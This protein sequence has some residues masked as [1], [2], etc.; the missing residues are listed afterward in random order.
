MGN[1][2]VREFGLSP[3]RRVERNDYG[4]LWTIYEDHDGLVS[5]E[6]IRLL[7]RDFA[8]IAGCM[9][10]EGT[11]EK[12]LQKIPNYRAGRPMHYFEV[13]AVLFNGAPDVEVP[14][15]MVSKARKGTHEC[16]QSN[17]ETAPMTLDIIWDFLT[18]CCCLVLMDP[19]VNYDFLLYYSLL[20]RYTA[21]PKADIV[22]LAKRLA[23][24][25]RVDCSRRAQLMEN[26]S[27]TG[28]IVE[29]I[30]Q[31]GIFYSA[32]VRLQKL[33]APFDEAREMKIANCTS[34]K[35]LCWMQ[36][37][38]HII[39]R[40][41]HILAEAF[42][43]RFVEEYGRRSSESEGEVA[44]PVRRKPSIPNPPR[45]NLCRAVLQTIVLLEGENFFLRSLASE[46][47]R[48]R[49]GLLIKEIKE[50]VIQDQ[51]LSRHGETTLESISLRDTSPRDPD[52]P[53]QDRGSH[54]LSP[55]SQHPG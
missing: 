19:T 25:V 21:S 47:L 42:H 7:L 34:F 27:N 2:L 10:E 54:S 33:L 9:F 29:Y 40:R 11:C 53:R 36:W 50:N 23:G 3:H 17:Q 20:H 12:I 24:L 32:V 38:L 1:F 14:A 31:W 49:I 26:Q 46:S 18:E 4:R 43:K 41:R 5:R 28:P 35:E 30:T 37:R 55:R 16:L 6:H 48:S 51:S 22:G 39:L 45:R 8:G 44:P 13:K 15:W 52:V